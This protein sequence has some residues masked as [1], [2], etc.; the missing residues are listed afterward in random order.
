MGAEAEDGA[1]G[2]MNILQRFQVGEPLKSW[3]Q[4][5]FEFVNRFNVSHLDSEPVIAIKLTVQT[6]DAYNKAGDIPVML[7]EVIP[8]NLSDEK[9]FFIMRYMLHKLLTHEADEAIMID[10]VR[11]YNPH[12]IDGQ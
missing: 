4:P 6:R 11:V 2:G 1:W 12:G 9:L 5:K 8:N 3:L 10:G 7:E